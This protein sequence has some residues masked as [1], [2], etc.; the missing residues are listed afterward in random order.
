M[1]YRPRWF[2]S[3]RL[4]FAK[5]IK[6]F[7]S[8][9]CLAPRLR[10]ISMDSELP[11]VGD[12]SLQKHGSEFPNSFPDVNPLDTYRAH[13]ASLLS[14]VSGVDANIIYPAIQWTQVLDKGDFILAVPAM[15]LKGKPDELATEFA[16]KVGDH[17]DLSVLG[18]RA[19]F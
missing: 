2:C 10:R 17:L 14:R 13:I 16:S 7:Y 12:L 18:F 8:I 1:F 4:P 5:P 11:K 19:F 6:R 15:R 9:P 3:P